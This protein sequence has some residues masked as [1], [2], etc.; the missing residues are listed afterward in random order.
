MRSTTRIGLLATS[1][2][3]L[4]VASWWA[5]GE[6][7]RAGFLGGPGE[8]VG[9]ALA[10]SSSEPAAVV[11]LKEVVTGLSRPVFLTHAGDG[12]SRLFLVEQTG[13]ILE[14]VPGT[15]P[16]RKTFLDVS[17]EIDTAEGER[18]L[19]GL[20]F[21]PEFAKNRHFYISFTARSGEDSVVRIAR[22]TVSASGAVEAATARTVLEMAD[23]ASNHNGGMLAFGPD[24]LLYVGTGD[25]GRAGDPWDNARNPRSLLGKM[26]RLDVGQLPYRIPA[27]NPFREPHGRPEIWALGLRNPWRYSFDRATG[28]L[29]IA[30]VGQN[31]WEE[32]HVVDPR[33]GAGTHFGWKTME[34]RHCFEPRR[35][36]DPTGLD[37]PIHEYGHELGC[38]ITGGYVYRGRR[39]PSLVGWYLFGDYCSGRIWALRREGS[40]V[41]VQELLKSS[42]SI[43]SFGEDEAGELYVCDHLGGRI[44]RIESAVREE[45]APARGAPPPS[46][47]SAPGNTLTTW[48]PG[49]SGRGSP[50][51]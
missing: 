9:P 23:P 38:S 27:G 5:R 45:A 8:A 51:R 12:S 50:S 31:S 44:Y 41:V 34:G 13:R 15:P 35:G 16:G 19:L 10:Q 1:L 6:L 18:G 49:S 3:A 36:C 17:R 4:A 20:A 29:W 2:V 37:L 42:L 48:V 32:I 11:T 22:Y 46:T 26:L 40:G 33:Q 24:R 7:T 43:S 25:G 14:L 47:S 28:E 30:D 39:I 21:D